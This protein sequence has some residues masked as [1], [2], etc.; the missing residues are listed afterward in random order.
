MPQD[1][2]KEFPEPDNFTTA[3]R[4]AM[5]KLRRD[6]IEEHIR[7]SP[8]APKLS[9]PK[10][11]TGQPNPDPIINEG[12]VRRRADLILADMELEKRMNTERAVQKFN[13][14]KAVKRKRK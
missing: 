8:N 9:L 4:E 13:R 2:K 7:K 5:R 6:E 10:V 14:V 1:K 11:S 12:E 3:F